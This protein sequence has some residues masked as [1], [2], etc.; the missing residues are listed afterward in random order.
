VVT[1]K[2]RATFVPNHRFS[3]QNTLDISKP[4]SEQTGIGS[5]VITLCTRLVGT[6]VDVAE[7]TDKVNAKLQL[8]LLTVSALTD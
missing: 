1:T 8:K 7:I 2:Q 6:T 4:S 5:F 3:W